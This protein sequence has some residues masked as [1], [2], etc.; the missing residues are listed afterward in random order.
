MFIPVAKNVLW[1]LVALIVMVVLIDFVVLIVGY[2]SYEVEKFLGLPVP[3]APWE[4]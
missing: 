4:K 2:V 3:P 1:Y